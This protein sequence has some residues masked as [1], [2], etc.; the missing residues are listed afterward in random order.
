MASPRKRRRF[1]LV[2]SKTVTLA[3]GGERRIDLH[4]PPAPPPGEA[5]LVGIVLD[6]RFRPVPE[7]CLFLRA[8]PGGYLVAVTRSHRR[9]RF[10][11][12]PLAPGKYRLQVRASGFRCRQLHLHLHRG[13][14]RLTVRLTRLR[15][16]SAVVGRVVGPDGA[17]LGIPVTMVLLRARRAALRRQ[18]AAADGEFAFADLRPGLYHIGALAEGYAPTTARVKVINGTVAS[19]SLRFGPGPHVKAKS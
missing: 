12:P 16:Q 19:L 8:E 7:A 10:H 5:I 1:G 4:L 9:G 2:R 18:R 3:A 13:I 6:G 11:F 17:P 15:A 14:Q